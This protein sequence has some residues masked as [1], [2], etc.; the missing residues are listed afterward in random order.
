M[1]LKKAFKF[2]VF[3]SIVSKVWSIFASDVAEKADAGQIRHKGTIAVF[4]RWMPRLR[5]DIMLRNTSWWNVGVTSISVSDEVPYIFM[6][7]YRKIRYSRASETSQ[8]RLVALGCPAAV[9]LRRVRT[10]LRLPLHSRNITCRYIDFVT[11]V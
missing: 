6:N 1:S 3:W 9:D 11:V 7:R 4:L 2:L 5:V 10:C 8:T